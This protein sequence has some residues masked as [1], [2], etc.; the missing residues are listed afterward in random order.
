MFQKS[1]STRDMERYLQHRIGW[2]MIVI[3][4]RT[5]QTLKFEHIIER[6]N[7]RTAGETFVLIKPSAMDQFIRIQEKKYKTPRG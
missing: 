5:T 4:G 2:T 6:M 7:K 1:K 3:R